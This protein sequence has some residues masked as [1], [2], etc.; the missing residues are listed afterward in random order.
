MYRQSTRDRSFAERNVAELER[1]L[2]ALE[3]QL[4]RSASRASSTVSSGMSQASD[5]VAELIAAA[6]NEAGSR[7]RGGARGVGAEASHL[8]HEAA[9]LGNDAVKRLAHEVEERPLVMLA[10]AAGLGLL[11][12]LAARRR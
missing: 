7:F 3:R 6:L 1:R 8:G 4:G 9:R 10:V 12:G 2:V 5:R 11:V